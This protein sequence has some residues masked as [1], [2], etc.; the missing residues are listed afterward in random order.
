MTACVAIRLKISCRVNVGLGVAIH[1][2]DVIT[3]VYNLKVDVNGRSLVLGSC[4]VCTLFFIHS[5]C[6]VKSLAKSGLLKVEL[7]SLAGYGSLVRT[8]ISAVT[9]AA[10]TTL[11]ACGRSF[12][13]A[14]EDLDLLNA[15]LSSKRRRLEYVGSCCKV[16]GYDI[17]ITND[18]CALN[19][20]TVKALKVILTCLGRI[21]VKS[22]YDLG[23]TLVFDLKG[24]TAVESCRVGLGIVVAIGSRGVLIVGK[25][26]AVCGVNH[27]GCRIALNVGRSHHIKNYTCRGAAALLAAAKLLAVKYGEPSILELRCAVVITNNAVEGYGVTNLGLSRHL[28][29]SYLTCSI[30]GAVNEK[31]ISILVCNVKVAVGGVI[32]LGNSTAYVVLLGGVSALSLLLA[33]LNSRRNRE[34]VLCGS[35]GNLD[36]KGLLSGFISSGGV[37]CSSESKGQ[38]G[39]VVTGDIYGVVVCFYTLSD[40]DLVAVNRPGYRVHNALHGNLTCN[41]KV[42]CVRAAKVL[43]HSAEILEGIVNALVG[44][45]LAGA[46]EAFKLVTSCKRRKTKH[47]SK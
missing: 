41:V 24:S 9:T 15:D 8:R 31:L 6:E 4:K 37:N 25:C 46:E 26:D 42:L 19:G 5:S 16:D 36:L 13:L 14:G 39:A 28:V 34:N 29:K 40:G 10:I 20:H 33:E 30:V 27:L 11:I 3:T 18:G 2:V 21:V 45:L 32:N 38:V 7:V 22:K 35:S 43:V 1:K 44:L 23:H 47:E 17:V 12:N